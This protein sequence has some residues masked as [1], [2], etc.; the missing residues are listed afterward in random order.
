MLK[1]SHMT[2]RYEIGKF[3]QTALDDVTL[4]F[5]KTEFVSILGPSGSGKTTMLNMIGGLDR[6][7]AG[8]LLING[9]STKHFTNEEW[10][11][12][13]NHSIGFVFQNYNL[14]NHMSVLANVELGMTLSGVSASERKTRSLAVLERVGLI[15]HV[16]KKPNQLSGGQMQRVAIARALVNDP[17][18]I[19]ADE[20]TGA[21]DTETSDQIMHLIKEISKDKLVIMVTHNEALA[22]EY[23]S[24]IVSLRDGKIISDTNPYEMKD[25]S[26]ALLK[27]KQ[28]SM[29]FSQALRL[30]F[31]NLRTKKF[32]TLITAF[33]GSIGIIGI[34]LVLSLANGLDSEINR[35]EMTTLA[36]FPVQIDQVAFNFDLARQGPP[37]RI[38]ADLWDEFPETDEVY[39]YEEVL[40]DIQHV[41]DISEDYIR[42]VEALDE[43]LY[44]QIS[45]S[46]S[47][48][49][50]VLHKQAEDNVYKLNNGAVRFGPMIEEPD[51]FDQSYDVLEGSMPVNATE[52]LLVVDSYN[53]LNINFFNALGIDTSDQSFTFTDFIGMQFKVPFLD[54]YYLENS[55]G[56]FYTNGD[57]LGLYGD[58][59]GIMLTISGIARV[60]ENALSAIMGQGLKYHPGLVETYL[61]N[62]KDARI[63]VAQMSSDIS[64]IT[65]LPTTAAQIDQFLKSIGVISTPS[66]IRIY[67][68]DFDAKQAITDHLDLFNEGLDDDMQVVYTD[69]AAI[70]TDL[71]SDVIDGISYVLIAFS[72]ISLVVSSIMI[73]II[74]Y[75]SVLERT[76]EI[77]LLRSLG[78]RRKDISRVFNAE[79]SI[80][81]FTAGIIGVVSAFLLTFPINWLIRRLVDGIENIAVMPVLA[82]FLLIVISIFLTFVSGLVPARIASRKDPVVALRID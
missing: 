9:K 78:A 21:I 4:A 75:V 24:R 60:K 69:L 62:A 51:F 65:G 63:G 30:S 80:I 13:R 6:F 76:K 54:D 39:P 77:G 7:D 47:V 15:D 58:D 79:T 55:E 27:L 18:I 14:I 64:V 2:K 49:M 74:T 1:L 53:R 5:R 57:L 20:P 37:E 70:V 67:P 48:N 44:H 28:T 42:H 40:L 33:A 11:S 29:A 8:D 31:S 3:K 66:Q 45:Y 82:F 50:T 22:H 52:L 61:D 17:D 26:S 68:V 59:S 41:N 36:E 56:R 71:T 19:L 16:D 12:Y 10:D 81:G 25:G 46:R 73:G 32:R 34:A 35:L 72:A 38:D 23:S 43:A